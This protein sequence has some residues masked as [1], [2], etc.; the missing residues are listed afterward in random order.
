MK[1]NAHTSVYCIIGNPV[2]H[3][4][5]PV[6]HNAAFEHTGINAVYV[7]FESSS[8]HH[9]IAAIK[10]LGIKGASV[11]IPF[12]VDV[13]QLCDSVD[14][15]AMRIGSI[16]TLVNN[17]GTIK[18]Y[19]TD[20]YGLLR[21]LE[22]NGIEYMNKKILI[23]GN[24][25]SARAIA[26]TLAEK[27][28]QVTICGRNSTNVKQLTDDLQKYFNTVHDMLINELK[29]DSTSEY[30]IVINTTPVGMK[31]ETDKLPVDIHLIHHHHVVV[32]IIY[33]PL[34]TLFLQKARE[35]G[36]T[37]ITGDYMLLYQAC[38][39]FE[40]W[41]GQPAPIDIMHKVLKDA[42]Q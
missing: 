25:G 8:V 29:P 14:T 32:D 2:R 12:K 23:I 11:T 18:G 34:Y 21:S 33:S 31:P 28:A 39:Q 17:N 37:V 13:L 38:M 36:C 41:T 27:N 20:G 9:A 26:Y 30:D 10:S 6:M 4:L 1:I 19:N 16:N 15:H 24:G 35:K 5:S 7:A 40:I 22:T 3:S 42:L